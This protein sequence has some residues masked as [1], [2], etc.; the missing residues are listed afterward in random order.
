MRI[1]CCRCASASDR[2]LRGSTPRVRGR[3]SYDLVDVRRLERIIVLAI[4]ANP[5]VD[6]PLSAIS[7][8]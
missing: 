4:E 2:P 7:G 3:L 6:E 5:A 8:W 1:V